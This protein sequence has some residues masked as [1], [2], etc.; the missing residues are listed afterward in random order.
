MGQVFHFRLTV[1]TSLISKHIP[2]LTRLL[3]LVLE[4]IRY[5]DVVAHE[6]ACCEFSFFSLQLWLFSI[7]L[8]VMTT[9]RNFLLFTDMLV[10]KEVLL[11]V[12]TRKAGILPLPD[13]PPPP[14]SR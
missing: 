8:L 10:G 12:G 4:P 9:N 14:L 3:N 5:L 6:A 13:Q 1:Q 2:R 11:I 7:I